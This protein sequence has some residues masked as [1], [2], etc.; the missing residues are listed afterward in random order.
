MEAEI[1]HS[2]RTVVISVS[3][4]GIGIPSSDLEHIFDR[5]FQINSFSQGTGL[6]LPISRAI[7]AQL[8]GSLTVESQPEQGSKFMLSLPFVTPP[9]LMA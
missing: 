8:G 3:D 6:G 2:A 7:S 5:F 1:N 9:E 4:T